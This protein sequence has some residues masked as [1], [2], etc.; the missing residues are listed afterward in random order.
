MLSRYF[1]FLKQISNRYRILDLSYNRIT[2]DG[3]RE[4]CRMLPSGTY[5]ELIDLSGNMMSGDGAR[6]LSEV[7]NNCIC[8]G[9]KHV[10]IHQGKYSKRT[11]FRKM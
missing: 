1:W 6:M 10:Y 11:L 3:I 9:V 2:D 8:L 5:C 7:A 4:L